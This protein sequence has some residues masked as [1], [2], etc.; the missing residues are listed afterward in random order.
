MYREVRVMSFEP[1]QKVLFKISSM[2][3]VMWFCKKVKL[4][5]RYIG[6]F[7]VFDYV[8]S[9]AYRLAFPPSLSGVH[10]KL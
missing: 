10:P 6:L 1:R 9:V 2:N 3:G 5:P 8:D 7:E 4:R